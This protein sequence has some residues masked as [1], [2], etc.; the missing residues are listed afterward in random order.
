MMSQYIIDFSLPQIV[1]ESNQSIDR[2]DMS[3][4]LLETALEP[5]SSFCT[6]VVPKQSACKWLITVNLQV[7]VII[8]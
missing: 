6:L 4:F 2:I 7:L 3:H 8:Q 1:E 5:V